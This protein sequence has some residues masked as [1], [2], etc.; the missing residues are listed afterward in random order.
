MHLSS[1]FE[2]IQDTKKYLFFKSGTRYSLIIIFLKLLSFL[3]EIIDRRIKWDQ[4]LYI[5][6]INK[7]KWSLMYKIQKMY[8][9]DVI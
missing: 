7:K 1:E 4:C 5:I 8:I 6:R 9:F 3:V 2:D